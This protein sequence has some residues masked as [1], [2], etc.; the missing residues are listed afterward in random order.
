M[1]TVI[2]DIVYVSSSKVNYGCV[3]SVGYVKQ[4]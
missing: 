2:K 4:H 1:N 3:G